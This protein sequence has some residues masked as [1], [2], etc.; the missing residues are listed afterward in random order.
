MAIVAT[1]QDLAEQ[2]N[3][4][5]ANKFAG[6]LK[7]VVPDVTKSLSKT[8]ESFQK[9]LLTG[10]NQKIQTAYGDLKGF[11]NT[12]DV[13]ISDLGEGFRDT[14]KVFKSLTDQF[15]DTDQKIQELREK[16]IF[17]EK[18]L[19][20]NKKNNNLEVR[21]TI[22]TDQQLF[23]KRKKLLAKEKELKDK[24]KNYLEQIR[25]FQSGEDTLSKSK[26]AN[27][28]KNFQNNQDEIKNTEELKK[29]YSGK[30]GLAVNLLDRF[31]RSL[32]DSAPSFLVAAFAPIIDIAR[33][34]QKT[35]G[36]L[37]S[38][39]KITA[40]FIGKFLP[41][42]VKEGF[43]KTM[44]GL[45][46]GFSS[47]GKSLKMASLG[48]LKF[49]KRIFLAGLALLAGIVTPLLPII[50]PMLKFAGI[51]TAVVAGLYLLK[52][53]LNALVDWFKNSTVGKLLGFDDESQEKKDKEDR[54]N[55]TGKYQGLEGETD[56]G[57]HFESKKKDKVIIEKPLMPANTGDAGVAEKVAQDNKSGKETVGGKY[58]FQDGVLQQNGE[59]FETKTPQKAEM[60]A[61]KIGDQVKV[62]RNNETGNYVIV[63]KD[64]VTAERPDTKIMQGATGDIE[65]I[66]GSK[67]DK[68]KKPDTIKKDL[69]GEGTSS[70]S[71]TTTVVNNQ[72]TT[73]TKVNNAT[74][75]F[76]PINTSSGDS[77]FDRQANASNF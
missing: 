25:K 73:E 21:A 67:Q 61:K 3:E 54:K 37:I 34:F 70:S 28:L 65:G 38:G 6:I 23:E 14:E 27:L 64:M 76:T 63:K 57:D 48:L 72:P 59:N 60:I 29:L 1:V 13:S 35:I 8:A 16:N 52:K 45:G 77:Y 58:N 2:Q 47:F 53:G 42:S 71:T 18:E 39:V 33:Q 56:L 43:S 31:E 40:N 50:I 12:F 10:S 7:S 32:E 4:E 24:D 17:A 44:K 5:L 55:A 69:K 30:G 19:F 15:A 74:N 9:A 20:V 26:K 46:A 66:T 49:V 68:F 75:M 51:V 36:L 11:L 41:D 22:L 62:A